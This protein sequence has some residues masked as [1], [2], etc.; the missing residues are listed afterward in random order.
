MPNILNRLT[1]YNS[2]AVER[3]SR[4]SN[5]VKHALRVILHVSMN[6]PIYDKLHPAS[7]NLIIKQI[8]Y[9]AN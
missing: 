5:T 2:D 9:K 3:C 7:F 6:L 1:I 4:D 8:V